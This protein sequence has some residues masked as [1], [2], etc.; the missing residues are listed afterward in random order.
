MKK[1]LTIL[2]LAVYCM[3][4]YGCEED[5][6]APTDIIKFEISGE[7]NLVA[8]NYTTLKLRVI[9]PAD[10]DVTHRSI[11]FK[12]DIGN[13]SN[14]AN[15]ITIE[16]NPQG[17]ADAYLHSSKPGRATIVATVSTYSANKNVNLTA[18]DI[19]KLIR[20]D[21]FD[22]TPLVADNMTERLVKVVI[23]KNTPSDKRN[24]T[25]VTDLG[26]FTNDATTINILANADGI[27]QT[28]IKS[29][30]PG[31]AKIK[32]TVNS[33][34]SEI[35]LQLVAPDPDQIIRFA[36]GL[37]TNSMADG[38]S[39]LEIRALINSNTAAAQRKV[40]FTTDQG[41]FG[42]GTKSE[43]VMPD[44]AGTARGITQKQPGGKSFCNHYPPECCP[45]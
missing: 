15:E 26:S 44:A 12:T 19:S 33:I 4:Q 14:E 18:V 1:S 8:D 6:I 25:F 41:S 30:K 7:E 40:T 42:N 45:Q 35:S 11:K 37:T 5:E 21:N 39:T 23:D 32:A 38:I 36:E 28:F 2:V 16:A 24:V 34:E 43:D 29:E 20:F 27:A 22:N 9:I 10:A 17:N 13:F 31:K 3:L